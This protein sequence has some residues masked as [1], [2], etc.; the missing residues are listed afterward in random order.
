MIVS[1][2]LQRA[3]NLFE[4]ERVGVASP[5]CQWFALA[6]DADRTLGA[7]AMRTLR[8]LIILAENTLMIQ[9]NPCYTQLVPIMDYVTTQKANVD[10][11]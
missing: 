10:T 9:L 7:V 8:A 4:Y 2:V 6:W 1:I 3:W 5:G 11:L